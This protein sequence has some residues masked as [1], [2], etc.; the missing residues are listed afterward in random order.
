MADLLRVD[1]KDVL[2]FV[3]S[4]RIVRTLPPDAQDEALRALRDGGHYPFWA[5]TF[6][7][8]GHGGASGST[9]WDS[10]RYGGKPIVENE[11]TPDEEEAIRL[12][13]RLVQERSKT[14]HIVDVGKETAFRRFI[15]EHRHHLRRFP[16]LVRPDG[17]R[18]EG[19]E[20]FT[21]EK[22]EAFLS[23]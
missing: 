17:R 6:G 1:R 16:V 11:L 13:L 15:E 3:N 14:L 2:M 20:E 8:A 23:D 4:L 12:V 22:L 5:G 18:L 9:L 19:I 10:G 7:Y 21:S